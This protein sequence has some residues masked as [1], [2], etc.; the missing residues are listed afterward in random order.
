MPGVKSQRRT[1]VYWRPR[2]AAMEEAAGVAKAVRADE[3]VRTRSA[4]RIP[5][6]V[7]DSA[8]LVVVV[9]R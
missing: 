3:I 1:V 7:L 9:G 4:P 5:R 2:E 6:P 8:A